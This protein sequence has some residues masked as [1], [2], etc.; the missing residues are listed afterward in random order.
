MHD[1]FNV[2]NGKNLQPILYPTRLLFRIEGE[3]KSFPEK[4]KLREFVNQRDSLGGKERPKV[5]KTKKDQR[6]CPETM[7]KQVIKCH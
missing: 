6:K 5:T 2:L 3:I 7:T 1:I 4:S